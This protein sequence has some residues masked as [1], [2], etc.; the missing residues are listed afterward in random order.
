M[1]FSS[2]PDVERL[3]STLNTWPEHAVADRHLIPEPVLRTA[4]PR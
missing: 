1:R 3:A 4:V 2:R